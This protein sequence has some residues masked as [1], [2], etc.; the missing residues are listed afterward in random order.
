MVL[1]SLSFCLS[2]KL[3][4]SPSYLN[5][6]L[7]GYSNL[8]CRLLSFITLSMC[9]HS[10]LAWRVSIE[11][12]AVILMGIPLCVIF[13]LLLL[14]FVLCVWSLLIWLI[15]VLG[16][17]PWVYPIWNQSVPCPV[18]TV[19]SWPAYRFSRG[20]SGSS[21]IPV[22]FRIFS[23]T[24]INQINKDQTQRTNNKSSKGKTTNNTQGDSH[25]ITA[26]LSIETLQAR[27]EGQ[28]ILKV[29]K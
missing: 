26:D 16:F 15:C 4:I 23:K 17:S 21:D 12:S 22:S 29:M 3:L 28:D 27:R 9:C 7:A 24:Y 1:N 10:L 19:A 8:G 11:R 18:L 2:G 13:P 14:I 20:R 5:E 6:I 25:S